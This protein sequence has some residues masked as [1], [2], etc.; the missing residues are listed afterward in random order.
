ME[1]FGDHQDVVERLRALGQ[2]PV[3]PALASAH[4]TAMAGG[5]PGTRGWTRLKVGGA[6]LAGLLLGGTG[7]ASAGALPDPVQ[8]AAHS[9]LRQVGID[10]P[11]GHDRYDGPECG[12]DA[13]GQAF[14]NHGQYVKANKANNPEA[15]KSRCGKPVK[16][17]Q[18]STTSSSA[19]G[20]ANRN[21]A[22]DNCQGPPPWATDKTMTAEEK[23]AAQAARRAACPGEDTEDAE[24]ADEPGQGQGAGRQN[25][26]DQP[27]ASSPA[28]GRPED[29]GRSDAGGQSEGKAN[30]GGNQGQGTTTT[31]P[32]TTVPEP[33]TTTVNEGTTTTSTL[34]D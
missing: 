24:D 21:S 7:L 9:A 31:A 16:A 22:A 34:V 17:G 1:D 26:P 32:S 27:T 12:K 18:G 25:Q 4:L 20:A 5:R 10:V 11:P 33:T 2:Q 23:T 3:E 28:T 30:A 14:R 15:G 13:N 6:F 19:P 29:P 8:Q